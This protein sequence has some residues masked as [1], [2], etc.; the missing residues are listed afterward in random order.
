MTLSCAT[1]ADYKIVALTDLPPPVRRQALLWEQTHIALLAL[2]LKEGLLHKQTLLL[3]VLATCFIALA[4]GL[5]YLACS[6]NREGIFFYTAL[7]LADFSFLVGVALN[8]R[9]RSKIKWV[10]GK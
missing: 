9:R 1:N 10:M 2:T 8:L 4:I 3:K 6:A 5:A 7:G